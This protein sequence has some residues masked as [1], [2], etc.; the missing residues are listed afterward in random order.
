MTYYLQGNNIKGSKCPQSRHN[1]GQNT[2]YTEDMFKVLT[3]ESNLSKILY[4]V[5]IS[6]RNESEDFHFYL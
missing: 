4:P 1:E 3:E 6:F 5:K 2:I